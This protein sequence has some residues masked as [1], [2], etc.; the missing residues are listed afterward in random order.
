M[1]SELFISLV[2]DSV[3]FLLAGAMVVGALRLFDKLT[4]RKFDAETMAEQGTIGYYYAARILA[5]FLFAASIF[6]S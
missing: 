5:V 4:G 2:L 3:E 6:G 1:I